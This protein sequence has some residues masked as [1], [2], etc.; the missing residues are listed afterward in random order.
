MAARGNIMIQTSTTLQHTC[1]LR[2]SKPQ[3]S[4]VPERVPGWIIE[5]VVLFTILV[6]SCSNQRI[7]SPSSQSAISKCDPWNEQVLCG[8]IAHHS[9]VLPSIGIK[10]CF[11]SRSPP[12]NS[13]DE[14]PILYQ[15]VR[16]LTRSL[17]P[18]AR[19]APTTPHRRVP[20]SHRGTI[21]V[22]EDED[23]D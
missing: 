14:P 18:A 23:N 11:S 16:V 4:P 17:T 10:L 9:S 13:V 7:G 12:T 6:C 15:C 3:L 21:D 19:V 5:T 1:Y 2:V 22:E 8:C 20:S